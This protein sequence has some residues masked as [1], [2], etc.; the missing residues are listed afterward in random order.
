MANYP[1]VLGQIT[2][3]QRHNMGVV[4]AA[5]AVRPFAVR[6]GRQFEAL[7]LL[8]NASNVPVEVRLWL[9]IPQVDQ[10]NQRKRFLSKVSR[11][12]IDLKP[13]EVGIAN[14]PISTLPDT[15]LGTGYELAIELAQKP[16]ENPKRLR[17]AE[18]GGEVADRHLRDEVKPQIEALK[19]LRFLTNVKRGRRGHMFTATFNVMPGGV[20]TGAVELQPSWTNLWSL[21]DYGDVGE[22]LVSNR[23]A[24]VEKML[25]NL[26]RTATVKPLEEAAAKQ[27]EAAGL[28]LEPVEARM[29]SRMMALIL[30]FADAENTGHGTLAAGSYA[31]SPALR[32]VHPDESL[33]GPRWM[34]DYVR[35]L[36]QRPGLVSAPQQVIPQAFFLPLL[37]DTLYFCF[38]A[39]KTAT[40]ED[41]GSDEEI[42]TY[43][44]QVL[45]RMT[46]DSEPLNV[47]QLYLPLVIGGLYRYDNIMLES[48]TFQEVLYDL[49]MAL[50]KRQ[51]EDEDDD[52]A[53]V[54]NMMKDLLER[55]G[56]RYER[57]E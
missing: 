35:L 43:I 24:V 4:Q 21:A 10:K 51:H 14:L 32:L 49:H 30:E 29:I 41:L 53:P 16:A 44:D 36:R 38:E 33:V 45:E 42:K 20:T 37:E 18:G 17:D 54:L 12:A 1:D 57:S 39:V 9:T 26:R 52:H 47:S 19:S 46:A 27:F 55:I 50:R 31:L 40:G 3:G 11:L 48:E 13:A 8:Q 28:A 15:A 23:D 5:M 22:Y 7:L 6:A 2:G 34:Q 56:V 25:P